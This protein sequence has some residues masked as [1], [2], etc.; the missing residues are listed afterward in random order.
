MLTLCIKL[1]SFFLVSTEVK[2]ENAKIE[3][4]A[5]YDEHESLAY[6]LDFRVEES[7]K[8]KLQLASCSFYDSL[9]KVWNVDVNLKL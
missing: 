9:L 1:N 8:D 4:L 5:Q 3:N 6:G 2:D 7:N